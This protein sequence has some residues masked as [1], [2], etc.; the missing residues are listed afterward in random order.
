LRIWSFKWNSTSCLHPF[1]M[2][3][4]KYKTLFG[5]NYSCQKNIETVN[6]MI[7]CKNYVRKFWFKNIRLKLHFSQS[8]G[9]FSNCGN[10]KFSRANLFELSSTVVES[11]FNLRWSLQFHK[12]NT[13]FNQLECWNL[14][15]E[16]ELKN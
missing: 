16:T 5:L 11:P 12:E 14:L 7:G 6:D 15:F 3:E 8:L 4:S 9:R 13:R 10:L 2:D 1:W